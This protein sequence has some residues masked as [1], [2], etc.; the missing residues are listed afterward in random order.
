MCGSKQS[1]F[2]E[3]LKLITDSR[4]RNEECDSVNECTLHCAP[5]GTQEKKSLRKIG[6]LKTNL[7]G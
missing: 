3:A 1:K 2:L 7:S 5:L 6:F 4:Q